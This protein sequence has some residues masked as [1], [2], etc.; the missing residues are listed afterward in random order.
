MSDTAVTGSM[1]ATF[2][3]SVIVGSVLGGVFAEKL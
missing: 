3:V 2:I 1:N